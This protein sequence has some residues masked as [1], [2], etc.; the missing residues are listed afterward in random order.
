M[1]GLQIPGIAELFRVGVRKCTFMDIKFFTRTSMEHAPR[2][3]HKTAMLAA[4]FCSKT[5]LLVF[6][7]LFGL[8][9]L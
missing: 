3:V 7:F 4:S 9:V 8:P 6:V 2:L 1:Y 5:A